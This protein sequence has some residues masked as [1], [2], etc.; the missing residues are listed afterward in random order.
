ML[1]RSIEEIT[2]AISEMRD[3]EDRSWT[4]K[5]LETAKKRL[6]EQLKELT[7]A[8]KDDLITFEELGI[9]SIMVDDERDIIGTN[10]RKPSKIKGSQMI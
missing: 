2:Y 8:P 5:Q 4:V 3:A 7:D 10:Q 6:E 9:D 1:F